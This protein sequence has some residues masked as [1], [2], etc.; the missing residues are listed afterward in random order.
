[1]YKEQ[2]QNI[3][4]EFLAS[5]C[6]PITSTGISFFF[7]SQLFCLA[8][9]GSSPTWCLPDASTTEP[10]DE[11]LLFLVALPLLC[12]CGVLATTMPL[13][14]SADQMMLVSQ[15]AFTSIF[16]TAWICVYIMISFASSSSTELTSLQQFTLKSWTV[17]AVYSTEYWTVPVWNPVSS[18]TGI[19]SGLH[20][21]TY[22]C[23][24]FLILWD[25]SSSTKSF[26]FVCAWFLR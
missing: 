23:M 19:P 11:S 8:L 16:I 10:S 26:V 17:T 2:T 24:R 13:W 6:D 3:L 1:M 18:I 12:C 22:Y 4:P 14:L 20:D 9:Y 15:L 25:S 21:D 5:I 7:A